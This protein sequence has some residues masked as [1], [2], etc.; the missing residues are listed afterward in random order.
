M[1]HLSDEAADFG[2]KSVCWRWVLGQIGVHGL[3]AL[4]EVVAGLAGLL[5]SK[6]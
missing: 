5:R 6:E 1:R 2:P 4:F 3:E